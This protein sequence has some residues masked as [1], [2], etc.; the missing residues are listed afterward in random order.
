M[1]NFI[2]LSICYFFQLGLEDDEDEHVIVEDDGTEMLEWV[3]ERDEHRLQMDNERTSRRPQR[4]PH[5]LRRFSPEGYRVAYREA[6]NTRYQSRFITGRGIMRRYASDWSGIRDTAD[7][8]QQDIAHLRVNRRCLSGTE[9]V[10]R[11]RRINLKNEME[12]SDQTEKND[13]DDRDKSKVISEESKGC[14]ENENEQQPSC[15]EIDKEQFVMKKEGHQ[16]NVANDGEQQDYDEEDVDFERSYQQRNSKAIHIPSFARRVTDH[17][18]F[19][20]KFYSRVYDIPVA[21]LQ[22]KR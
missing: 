8:Y 5:P 16:M 15:S 10:S 9:V 2:S 14:E 22:K 4:E 20:E 17:P 3:A 21:I 18:I 13:E 1:K 7:E 12:E 19:D 6:E 11:A